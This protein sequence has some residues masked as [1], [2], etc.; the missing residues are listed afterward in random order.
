MLS[1]GVGC[2]GKEEVGTLT[3]FRP[4]FTVIVVVSISMKPA[5]G[6]LGTRRPRADPPS[7]PKWAVYCWADRTG[8]PWW[9][10]AI[11]L[12]PSTGRKR[13]QSNRATNL[14][15]RVY[16]DDLRI[17]AYINI[18]MR[19][20]S[21][22]KKPKNITSARPNCTHVSDEPHLLCCKMENLVDRK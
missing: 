22:K 6:R 20:R 15:I 1:A 14:R 3:R 4:D 17:Y 5:S 12:A 2:T 16:R 18:C 10:C 7:R 19:A 8:P 13:S 9:P 21:N 11:H